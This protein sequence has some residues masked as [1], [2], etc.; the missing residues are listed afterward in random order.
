ME[1]TR[2]EDWKMYLQ[3]AIVRIMKARKLLW[4][5]ALLQ[6]VI[7]QSRARFNPG[8][9]MI[10]KCIKLLFDK[11]YIE[12]SQASTNEYSSVA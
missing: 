5:N 9:S 3:A 7:S 1:Q 6:E 2:S 4:H 8:I 11:Q 10:K 12:R